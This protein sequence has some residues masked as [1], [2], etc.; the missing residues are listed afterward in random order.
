MSS[1]VNNYTIA[2]FSI[3]FVMIHFTSTVE[4]SSKGHFGTSHFV[5][6]RKAVLFSEVENVLHIHFRGYW[7]CLC[8]EVVPF[9]EGPLLE[10][11]LIITN[12]VELSVRQSYNSILQHLI[13]VCEYSMLI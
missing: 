7:K 3:I 4:P 2:R 9:L 5:S 8:R 11:P 13:V 12:C 10:V 6:C 1:T